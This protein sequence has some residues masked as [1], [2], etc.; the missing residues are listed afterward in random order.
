MDGVNL[1]SVPETILAV[2]LRTIVAYFTRICNYDVECNNV[3]F[4]CLHREPS[5]YITWKIIFLRQVW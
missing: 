5:H 1:E 3:F 2:K 4:N